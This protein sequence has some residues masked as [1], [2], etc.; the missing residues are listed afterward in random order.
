MSTTVAEVKNRTLN[1]MR[2]YSTNGELSSDIDYNI[3]FNPLINVHQA[4][5]ARDTK[6]IIRDFSFAQNN[7][8]NLV[9]STFENEVFTEEISFESTGAR[10]FSF[11]VNNYATIF[12][13]EEILG[14]WT[15]LIK[16]VKTLT[17]LTKTVSAV[18]TI[19]PLDGETKFINIKGKTGISDTANN[20]RIRFDGEFT[21]L[22]RF[23]ALFAENY[24]DDS[25]CPQFTPYVDYTLPE[26]FSQVSRVEREYPFSIVEGYPKYKFRTEEGDI[27]TI[28]IAW[29]DE[30]QFNVHYYA[31]P[32]IIPQAS[33]SNPTEFDANIIDI[34]DETV[35]ALCMLLASDLLIDEDDFRS[36]VLQDNAFISIN[37]IN[38]NK[39]IE[40]GDQSIINVRNW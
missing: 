31:K 20:V 9:A 29:D 14:V 37:N 34:T 3:S 13:E 8:N 38:E 10:A 19:T 16:Y 30:G 23:V 12:I 33:L 15:E 22:Y 36:G 24:K 6:N 18:D 40:E 32:T 11:D 1:L 26:T 17:Q 28:S 5:I 39:V 25:L 7:P 4:A 35:D 2:E 21:Y 27:K